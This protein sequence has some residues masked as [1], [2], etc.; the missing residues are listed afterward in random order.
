MIA[1]SSYD[2]AEELALTIYKKFAT[3][4]G[5]ST[6]STVEKALD[7]IMQMDIAKP[8]DRN[9]LRRRLEA[10]VN[11]FISKPGILQDNRGH[12]GWL[13][14]KK[15]VVQWKFWQRYET[16]LIRE[17]RWYLPVIESLDRIT[18]DVLGRLE[19]PTDTTRMFDRRGMVVGQ[20]QSGKTA[21][22]TGLICKAADA[23]YKV[24]IVLAGNHNSLRSQTQ[25]RLD[26]EFL[27]YE[28]SSDEDPSG[29]R[30]IGVSKYC[31]CPLFANSLT[32]QKDDGDFDTAIRKKIRM[33][34]SASQAPQLLVIKKNATV[35]RNVCKYF[36]QHPEAQWDE[37]SNSSKIFSVPLLVIDDEADL[38]SINTQ[39]PTDEN[40][41]ILRDYEPS[42]INRLVREL[43]TI[44]QRK[45]YVGYTATPFANIFIYPQ[46]NHK[47]YG[48]DLFPRSFIIN[49]PTPPDYL[50]PVQ[51]FG[52]SDGE[53]KG[54]PLVRH[55]EEFDSDYQQFVPD[56][57][58]K[59]LEPGDVP[60]SLRRAMLSYLL[61]CALRS[62]RGC[63][64]AHNTMLIHVTRYTDVQ[65][66]ICN[67]VDETLQDILNMLRFNRSEILK[68]FNRIY[69]DDYI[70]TSNAMG[71]TASSS[72]FEGIYEHLIMA[73]GKT[74][75]KIINGK[76]DD[77]LDYKECNGI[78][79]NVISIGGDKLSR[80]LTLE[81]L[82][83]SYYLRKTNMYDTLMQ[84]G[85]WFGFRPGYRDLCRMYITK[86][87]EEWFE[88]IT[89]ASEE[90][91]KEFDVMVAQNKTPENYGLRVRTHS[92][93]L[94]TSRVKMRSGIDL[95]F[96]YD[97]KLNGTTALDLSKEV[98]EGNW[99]LTNAF[100]HDLNAVPDRGMPS[101]YVWKNVGAEAIMDFL[102]AFSTTE[103]ST[104]TDGKKIAY[105]IK[106]QQKHRELLNWTVA[107]KSLD[108]GKN[109][110]GD[111]NNGSV[112]T[113]SG[114]K[115]VCSKRTPRT[116]N[117]PIVNIGVLP[118]GNDE[119]VDLT[120]DEIGRVN[121]TLHAASSED[122]PKKQDITGTLARQFRSK[123]RGLLMIYPI[124]PGTI[125][126][127]I[128]DDKT[129]AID[130]S[131]KPLEMQYPIVGF[132]VSF[133]RSPNPVRM[134]YKVT[135]TWWAA[136]REGKG[137]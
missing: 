92:G 82:T 79:L 11:V 86:E 58:N 75:I 95:D 48:P 44:F 62:K 32:S 93:L 50:G 101:W 121:E 51:L 88:S 60:N 116:I 72:D 42:R 56:S 54:L 126:N 90:L 102:K 29:R 53:T 35:L 64:N 132:A 22:F 14:L 26:E 36:R 76:S 117:M 5:A 38:A 34:T 135:S 1:D 68:E 28:T 114:Y 105:Y 63:P 12:A 125:S 89:D 30:A 103:G 6:E 83:V 23:G 111:P 129:Q 41:Q 67:K 45:A 18:D 57:H 10:R 61:S 133:P 91:R 20:V 122:G 104:R 123:E 109:E 134:K 81:G 46:D 52:S 112:A 66:R 96:T 77:I 87:L 7:N 118:S 97:G 128:K 127:A 15:N 85:R 4:E 65:E 71:V 70:P 80:G 37:A 2:L 17:K 98:I 21:N 73:A 19:D 69:V 130:Q 55:V 43:L 25:M 108:T 131:S 39:D 8:L 27:G 113:I 59:D 136:D 119:M 137:S 9:E 120:P 106:M 33:H 100:I 74:K 78:G 40:G 107:L 115:V 47:K 110:G 49:L 99:N 124:D 84:M 24:I 16:Y 3:S 13:P 31:D 94:I